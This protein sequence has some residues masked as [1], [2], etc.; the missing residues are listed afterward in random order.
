MWH[1]L[2][3]WDKVVVDQNGTHPVMTCIV[4]DG[5]NGPLWQGLAKRRRP[6]IKSVGIGGYRRVDDRFGNA[7]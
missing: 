3:S 2:G 7:A 4:R 6:C 1:S 5:V